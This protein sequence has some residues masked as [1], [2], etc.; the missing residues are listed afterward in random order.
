LIEAVIGLP[1]NL[2]Y[3]AGIPAC[4][5]V[6]R[7]NLSGQFPNLSKPEGRRGCVLF[8]NADAEFHAGRA[9]NYLLPEHIEKIVSTYNKFDNV[10][11]YANRVSL[12]KISGPANDWTLNIRRYVDNAPPPEPHDVRAHLRG[13]VPSIEVDS[14][15]ALFESLNFDPSCIFSKRNGDE[16]YLDFALELTTGAQLALSSKMILASTRGSKRCVRS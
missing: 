8:I 2:F 9:Q 13:G 6:M 10:D 12:D 11:D 14:K 7:P 1:P 5:L 4:I 15:R 3:G 16:R